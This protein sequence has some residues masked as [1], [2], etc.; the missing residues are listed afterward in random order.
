MPHAWTHD[1]AIIG[2]GRVGIPLALCFKEQGLSVVAIDKNET[3][4]ALLSERKMP[5]EEPRCDVLL[6]LH[7]LDI[8]S[9]DYECISGAKNVI[10]TV[11]TPVLQHLEVDL[12][13][14]LDVLGGISRHLHSG[15]NVILRSTVGPGCMKRCVSYVNCNS[16]FVVGEQIGM[17]YCPERLAEGFACNEIY[18]LPQIIAA[19]DQVSHDLAHGL[20]QKLSSK[21]FHTTF[22]VG[23]LAKVCSNSYR[24]LQ[25]AFGNMIAVYAEQMGCSAYEVIRLCNEQYPRCDIALPG[26]CAG[27]CLRKDFAMLSEMTPQSDLMLS[28]WKINEG[29]PKFLVDTV[30]K[31]HEIQNFNVAVLGF[32]FKKDAD[33]SRDSL[34][35]KL[36]RYVQ[37]ESPKS[38]KIQDPFLPETLEGGFHN[39]SLEKA[40]QDADILFLACNH[41]VYTHNVRTIYDAC[42]PDCLVC[43]IWNVCKVNKLTFT[44]ADGRTAMLSSESKMRPQRKKALVT[45]GAGFIGYFLSKRLADTGYEVVILDNFQRGR[46]DR[47]L[48][49]L[50]S[51]GHVTLIEAD[52][53]KPLNLAGYFD[54]VFH[55]AAVNGTDNFYDQ[56][57]NVL[58]TNLLTTMNLLEWT[59]NENCGKFVFTSSAEAYAGTISTV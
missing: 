25:F 11:G 12:S 48:N 46:R 23:E 14:V 42:K 51:F 40:L 24:Y 26:L 50:L 35:P 5:F 15:H 34:T 37:K 29:M 17:S 10:V 1:V 44:I 31:T 49:E 28:A 33:D 6:S 20:F 9:K 53:C 13:Q 58:R 57:Q 45:G 55:L 4:I 18:S 7:G 54:V 32:A 19:E 27:S 16:R 38:L 52:L 39:C 56:P 3:T 21:I 30:L 47:C 41:S 22:A 59:T 2:V 8:I 43:D 36:I